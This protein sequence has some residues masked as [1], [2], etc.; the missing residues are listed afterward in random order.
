MANNK[1][2][3]ETTHPG[4]EGMDD[5]I[6]PWDMKPRKF[7]IT[8]Y[9]ILLSANLFYGFL[10]FLAISPPSLVWKLFFGF[11]AILLFFFL[12]VAFW[13]TRIKYIAGLFAF[14]LGVC[15][16]QQ[17]MWA[18][19]GSYNLSRVNETWTYVSVGICCL[20][21]ILSAFTLKSE[22]S[23][24]YQIYSNLER[25]IELGFI[26]PAKHEFVW[27]HALI[28]YPRL[29][30]YPDA[31]PKLDKETGSKLTQPFMVIAGYANFIVAL[32]IGLFSEAA[33]VGVLVFCLFFITLLWGH[34]FWK[35]VLIYRINGK[36]KK[37]YGADLVLSANRLKRKHA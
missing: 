11:E 37:R 1:I 25:L 10:S 7:V 33:L 22:K 27:S 9:A 14:L 28:T 36:Y 30:P 18:Y 24:I 26:N 13:I 4:I 8:L 32:M 31:L 20:A 35:M 21:V 34:G 12:G 15:I 3:I 6:P 23:Q 19:V 2:R 29:G 16:F 5:R 17:C